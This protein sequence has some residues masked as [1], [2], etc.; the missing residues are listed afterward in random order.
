MG[1]NA[2]LYLTEGVTLILGKTIVSRDNYSNPDSD[3]VFSIL[4]LFKK[5]RITPIS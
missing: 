1:L 4:G 5:E 2:L 3:V